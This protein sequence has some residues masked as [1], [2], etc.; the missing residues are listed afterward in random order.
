MVPLPTFYPGRE[1]GGDRGERISGVMEIYTGID[2]V[3]TD[4]FRRATERYG[5][6]FLKRVFT[7]KELA[8]IP[9]REENLYLSISFS[10]KESVW[11]A[12]PEKTQKDFYFRDIEVTWKRR[13]PI[14][15]LKGKTDNP[16]L[17]LHF[18][19]IA[20]SVVTTAVLL[21]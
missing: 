14:V 19:T 11:K 20:N 8:A 3:D 1:G 21:L 13:K 5:D 2:I 4:R 12:L 10:F 6:R 9:K 18:F 7:D 17:S 15:S 16:G